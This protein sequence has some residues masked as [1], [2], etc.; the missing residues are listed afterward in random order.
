MSTVAFQSWKTKLKLGRQGALCPI[1]FPSV[2]RYNESS[3]S[4]VLN[5]FHI[6]Q[7]CHLSHGAIVN[8]VA[9]SWSDFGGMS[10]KFKGYM[11]PMSI[12]SWSKQNVMTNLQVEEF[13]RTAQLV[14]WSSSETWWITLDS[15]KKLWMSWTSFAV[16]DSRYIQALVWLHS[17]VIYLMK[18]D[19]ATHISE[20]QQDSTMWSLHL[21]FT[22][23]PYGFSSLRL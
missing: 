20:W 6:F 16:T 7:W 22:I 4:C 14:A 23:Q 15:A 9:G 5:I 12:W 10:W 21:I 3:R 19:N 2:T 17:H 18:S 11:S 13:A 8:Q 1:R